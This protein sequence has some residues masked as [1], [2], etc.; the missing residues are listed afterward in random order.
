MTAE[1]TTDLLE[2]LCAP[3]DDPRPAPTVAVFAAHPDDES[4]GLGGR[5]PRLRS[6]VFFY[7]TDGAPRNMRDAR[8]HRFARREDYAAARRVELYSALALAG[9]TPRQIEFLGA[10]DQE[11]SFALVDLAR[12]AAIHLEQLQPDAIVTHPYEGGHPDHDATAFAVHAAC[13]L[14]ERQGHAPPVLIEMTSYHGRHGMLQTGE[15][16]PG[17]GDATVAVRLSE[18]ERAFKRRL[19]DCY[20]TQRQVLGSFPLDYERFRPAPRYDFTRPPHAGTLFYEQFDWAITGPR[21]RE[22]VHEAL[23][24]LGIPADTSPDRGSRIVTFDSQ[25]A[26]LNAQS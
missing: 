18:Q 17:T 9:M 14:L 24:D 15:F 21:W 25:L 8:A 20:R 7:T 6:A 11:A 10:A 3:W 12:A 23:H 19:F 2:R 22:L 5:L 1:V 4:V 13:R 16:L 26:T